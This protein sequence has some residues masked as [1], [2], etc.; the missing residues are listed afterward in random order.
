MLSCQERLAELDTRLFHVLNDTNG[1]PD[2]G[3]EVYL[4]DKDYDTYGEL[5]YW[6]DG[7]GQKAIYNYLIGRTSKTQKR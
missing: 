7:L 1:S 5:F 2:I 6:E 3:F 4:F